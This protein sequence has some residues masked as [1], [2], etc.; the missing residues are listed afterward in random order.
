MF[1]DSPPRQPKLQFFLDSER[2]KAVLLPD[3]CRLVKIARSIEAAM[4]TGIRKTFSKSAMIFLEQHQGST[5]YRKALSRF[6]RLGRFGSVS[7]RPSSFSVTI[8]LTPC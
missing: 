5:K 4:K 2:R 6:L 8:I 7:P 1:T 3:D